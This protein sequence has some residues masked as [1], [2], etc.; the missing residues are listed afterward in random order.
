MSPSLGDVAV[1]GNA[2][3]IPRLSVQSKWDTVQLETAVNTI[4]QEYLLEFTSEYGI[5][6]AL[7]PELPGSEDR[8]ADFSEGKVFLTTYL[9]TKEESVARTLQKVEVVIKRER[10]LAYAYSNQVRTGIALLMLEFILLNQFSI[11]A[12]LESITANF[13]A[14][15]RLV[16]PRVKIMVQAQDFVLLMGITSENVAHRFGMTRPRNK[17]RLQKAAAATASGKFKDEIIPVKTKVL[18][19]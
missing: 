14:W 16:Y 17:T 9:I 7:Q 8:I 15:D 6:K 18:Q 19:N 2:S 4:S 10:D 3:T 11:G 13:K 12:G 5:P 1:V